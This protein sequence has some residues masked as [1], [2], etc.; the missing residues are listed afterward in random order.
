MNVGEAVQE[1]QGE[2]ASEGNV[3]ENGTAATGKVFNS[4]ERDA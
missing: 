4:F 3:Q 2:A 1:A